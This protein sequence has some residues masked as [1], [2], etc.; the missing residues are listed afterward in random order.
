MPTRW[1]SG[2][3]ASWIRPKG[4]T[5]PWPPGR[6]S[7][8]RATAR[9][10][11]IRTSRRSRTSSPDDHQLSSKHSGERQGARLRVASQFDGPEKTKA[12]S[13][14]TEPEPDRGSEPPEIFRWI[15]INGGHLQDNGVQQQ[16]DPDQP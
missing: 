14:Q 15:G 13:N 6:R 10:S 3:P 7:T 12:E 9:P 8:S 16:T 2:G 1:R 4:T 5:S 11:R